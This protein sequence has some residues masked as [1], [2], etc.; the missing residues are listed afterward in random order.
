[1]STKPKQNT[2][3]KTQKWLYLLFFFALCVMFTLQN[4][5]RSNS[6]PLFVHPI[7]V[8]ANLKTAFA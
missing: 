2:F 8:I 5:F 3:T 4:Q 1:M 7:P 6:K